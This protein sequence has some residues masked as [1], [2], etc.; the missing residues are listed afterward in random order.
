M[1]GGGELKS[2]CFLDW[3]ICFS[4]RLVRIW[5]FD[6]LVNLL[7]AMLLHVATFGKLLQWYTTVTY[8]LMVVRQKY[9][10]D[11]GMVT[12]CWCSYLHQYSSL[13]KSNPASSTLHYLIPLLPEV[14]IFCYLDCSGCWYCCTVN[15]IGSFRIKKG[16]SFLTSPILS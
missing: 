7:S 13:I 15:F 2:I 9:P 4:F 10:W 5:K 6:D 14:C 11:F 8:V 16:C 12:E 1:T 3:E